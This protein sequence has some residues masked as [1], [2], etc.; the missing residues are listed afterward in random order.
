MPLRSFASMKSSP[1]L[2]S[3]L[4]ID[5]FRIMPVAGALAKKCNYPLVIVHCAFR[6]KAADNP[7]R[8]HLLITNLLSITLWRDTPW[9]LLF[10]FRQQPALNIHGSVR[11][12]KRAK[13]RRAPAEDPAR[14][15]VCGTANTARTSG[16]EARGSRRA[17]RDQKGCAATFEGAIAA[18]TRR[19]RLRILHNNFCSRFAVRS[20]PPIGRRLQGKPLMSDETCEVTL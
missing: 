12:T 19:E 2:R 17:S 5:K 14:V 9:F 3:T 13:H 8:F 10:F 11:K 7:K 1:F 20:A 16:G 18:R 6:P 4:T 15:A